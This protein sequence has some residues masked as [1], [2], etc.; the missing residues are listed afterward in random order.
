MSYFLESYTRGE[1]K[2]K[3]ELDLANYATKSDLKNAT[4]VDTSELEKVPTALNS[5]K[6]KVDG[7][8]V[9]KLETVPIDLSK[10]NDV[11]NNEVVKKIEYNK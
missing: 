6:N 8:G 7:L 2:I 1:N 3:F 11:V 9:D 4:G 5:L 10:L